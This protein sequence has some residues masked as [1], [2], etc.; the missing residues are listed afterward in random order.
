M[1]L[2]FLFMTD[3]EDAPDHQL[4]VRHEGL[5]VGLRQAGLHGGQGGRRRRRRR[6]RPDQ[7]GL[8]EEVEEAV[9][10]LEAPG[11]PGEGAGGALHAGVDAA[12]HVG[13]DHPTQVGEGARVGV[14]PGA[15]PG[16]VAGHVLA[17]R[18]EGRRPEQVWKNWERERSPSC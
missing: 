17:Q 10:E 8:A 7:A 12:G 11:G 9:H 3:R 2:F 14:V 1:F 6:R 13:A 16:E 4:V 15:Q 5:L 18:G